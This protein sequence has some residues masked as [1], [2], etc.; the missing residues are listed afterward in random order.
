MQAVSA[1]GKRGLGFGSQHR[2][3][4]HSQ[5]HTAQHPQHDRCHQQQ[6]NGAQVKQ[7]WDAEESAGN[8]ES[9]DV[10]RGCDDA[11][12]LNNK[13]M[14][15]KRRSKRKRDGLETET[16]EGEIDV[17]TRD[18]SNDQHEAHIL[19][20]AMHDGGTAKD[21]KREAKNDRLQER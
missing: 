12:G 1:V 10:E 18:E 6:H 17:N 15:R 9:G 7:S 16:E 14:R 8:V 11:D 21:R 13:T 4:Q 5:S 2:Q 20:H 19:H 3:R